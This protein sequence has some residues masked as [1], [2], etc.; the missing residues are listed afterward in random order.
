MTFLLP[1]KYKRAG[2]LMAPI[3]LLFW[4]IM[5]I[6]LLTKL[7]LQPLRPE[8]L[9]IVHSIMATIGFFAFLIGLYF[10][11]FSK[12]K[13]ED[14]MIQQLR[15]ESFQMAALLQ[16]ICFITGFTLM[17]IFGEPDKEGMLLFVL[18]GLFVFWIS[19]ILR[20]NFTLYR[21]KHA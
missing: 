7:G 5:Q 13:I 9:A 21:T 16:I 12:E 20:F 6:R 18:F 14:E 11:A 8:T 10:I 15:V 19:F 4:I 3:G 2:M 17:R 1:N